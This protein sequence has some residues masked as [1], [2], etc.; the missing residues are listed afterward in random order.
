MR[1]GRDGWKGV[2]EN[3]KHSPVVGD[4]KQDVINRT[5]AL[6]KSHSKCS[7]IIHKIDGSIQ[8]EQKFPRSAA[9]L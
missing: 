6:A 7:V 8:E 2:M 4:S 5:I 9:R 1:N 3:S